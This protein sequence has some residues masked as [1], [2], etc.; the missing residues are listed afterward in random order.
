[1]IKLGKIDVFI[2]I[3]FIFIACLLEQVCILPD[4]QIF[5]HTH[6][7]TYTGKERER[8]REGGREEGVE[9]VE[10]SRKG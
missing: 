4:F 5:L 3:S 8:E 7:C 2:E 6:K 9:S 1:M 10:G